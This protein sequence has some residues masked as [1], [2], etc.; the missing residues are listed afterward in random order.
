MKRTDKTRGLLVIL[1]GRGAVTGLRASLESVRATLG[2]PVADECEALLLRL[3]KVLS[4][5]CEEVA[6]ADEDP[7]PRTEAQL[8]ADAKAA[9]PEKP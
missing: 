7:E 6:I 1:S 2:A 9:A 5:V 4:S 3:D 8:A